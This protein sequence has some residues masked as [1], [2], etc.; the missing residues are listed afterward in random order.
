MVVWR[1]GWSSTGAA[2]AAGAAGALEL[3]GLEA[4]GATAG[5]STV[6]V[7]EAAGLETM[8]LESAEAAGATAGT[9]LAVAV[10]DSGLEA[11]SVLR[12]DELHG[13]AY[14]SRH[15][16]LHDLQ[17][18]HL[19]LGATLRGGILQR[20]GPPVVY[21]VNLKFFS[22]QLSITATICDD[23]CVS[24]Y[25]SQSINITGEPIKIQDFSF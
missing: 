20:A 11:F 23:N 14:S 15:P 9:L 2:G 22:V 16:S 18:L 5:L 24:H 13:Q 3:V 12:D 19:H 4:D 10:V 6:A 21:G 7:L 8:A 25:K 17:Y 1:A